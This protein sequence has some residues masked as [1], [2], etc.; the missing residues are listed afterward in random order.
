MI[1]KLLI[2]LLVLPLPIASGQDLF[3]E[4]FGEGDQQE[5]PI[6]VVRNGVQLGE[7]SGLV[8][9]TTTTFHLEELISVVQDIVND[10]T[11]TE[12]RELAG[13]RE[14]PFVE[15]GTLNPY[16][17]STVYR[18]EA[19]ELE[20]EI[21]ADRL[22]EQ[23][24][25][26]GAA[27]ML[28]NLQEEATVSGYLNLFSR[29][30]VS[31]GSGQNTLQAEFEPVVNWESWVAEASVVVSARSEDSE[32]GPVALPAARIVRDVSEYQIRAEAGIPRYEAGPLAATPEIYGVAASRQQEL[33]SNRPLTRDGRVSFV[34]PQRGPV[35]ISLN[36]RAFRTY[37]LSEGPHTIVD[38]P[39]GRGSNQISV[40]QSTE[41]GEGTTTLTDVRVPFAPGLLRPGKHRY[42]YA[43]G[44]LRDEPTTPI[45]SGRHAV[46]LLPELT[47]QA[48]AQA[49]LNRATAGAQLVGAGEWGITQLAGAL[50]MPGPVG[51][52]GEL[53][54]AISLLHSRWNPTVEV[55]VGAQNAAYRTI[56][57]TSSGGQFQIG[58]YYTQ[59]LPASVIMGLG[60]IRRRRFDPE[61]SAET[62]LR[63]TATHQSTQ[64]FS[65]NARFGPTITD[66]GVDWQGS[67]FIRLTDSGRSV[68][69]SAGYDLTD[70][71][72]TL[73][74]STVPERA[75][76]TWRWSAGYQGFDRS[77]GQPQILR[78]S[79]GY[80]GYLF[81]ARIEPYAQQT[82]GADEGEYRLGG[83]FSSA[84]A[85]AG[86][87]VAMSR[88]IRDSFV[89]VTPRPQVA[90]YRIPLRGSGG[91]LS[92]VVDGGAAVIPDL[93]SYRSTTISADGSYLP[94]GYSVGEGR[95]SFTPGYR[96]GYHLV[97]GSASSVYVRGRLI[98]GSG[99]PIAL[100]AGEVIAS[101]GS[102]TS[103]FTNQDGEF[104]ILELAPGEFRLQLYRDSAA[105]SVF[106]VPEG[107]VGRYDL[108][109]V[110]FL[111]GES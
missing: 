34:V 42:S 101:D 46:G 107:A 64:G 4:V 52:A 7:V 83:Q 50:S 105:E 30:V 31:S 60:A 23:V 86:R 81:S 25:N 69:T 89:L 15:V 12:L 68:T 8:S 35:E 24:L 40:T 56:A 104:E 36:G 75:V 18:P 54:H 87:Q 55:V 70:G 14:D 53:T 96:S 84:V 66:S 102:T 11:L 39:L 51:A 74:V 21:A 78:G 93:R 29:G 28:P 38:L 72:A 13:E 47:A 32:E 9:R 22:R 63:L 91:G 33:Q 57:S 111:Q 10:A 80:D 103:F 3:S 6:P 17:I 27:P 44:V 26:T 90:E 49:T 2:I 82:I 71:P 16:G 106:A 110:V 48:S 109:D 77:A 95:Y 85:F 59:R 41:D 76:D 58:A 45:V 79:A 98:D 97:I 88:P 19:V 73:S 37:N 20:V 100:E 62:S 94:D 92:S 1:A 5:L 108:E 67:L 99:D 61:E 43:A 65:V